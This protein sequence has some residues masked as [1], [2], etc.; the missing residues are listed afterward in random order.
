M[1]KLKAYMLS[2][3]WL[4]QIPKEYVSN[5]G[6]R[7]FTV[8]VKAKNKKEVA[9]ML[10][11]SLYSLN[12]MGFDERDENDVVGIKENRKRIGDIVQKDKTIYYHLEHIK[13]VD[14]N[15]WMEYS[16]DKNK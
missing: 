10:G 5:N 4:S 11:Q 8:L 16:I 13:N 6:S 1:K 3:V 2:S 12:Q 7:Q 14:I 15:K 9:E